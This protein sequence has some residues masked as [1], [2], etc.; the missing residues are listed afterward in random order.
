LISRSLFIAMNLYGL[1]YWKPSTWSKPDLLLLVPGL[2][3][4]IGAGYLLFKAL[5]KVCK[6]LAPKPDHPGQ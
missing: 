2:V 1:R 6:T 5:G 4:G 3:A